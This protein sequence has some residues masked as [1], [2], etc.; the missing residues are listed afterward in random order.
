MDL[1]FQWNSTRYDLFADKFCSVLHW[2]SIKLI[3]NSG[4][5]EEKNS[6][7]F[8]FDGNDLLSSCKRFSIVAFTMLFLKVSFTWKVVFN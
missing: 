4:F 7:F 1:N 3:Y 8:F 6:F 5:S 2:I